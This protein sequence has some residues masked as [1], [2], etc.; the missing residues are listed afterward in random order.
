MGI[1]NKSRER[2]RGLYDFEAAS[3][4]VTTS[5]MMFEES[6]VRIYIYDYN[7]ETTRM[8]EL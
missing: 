7:T 3:R 8:L 1:F 6:S 4:S 2:R 5:A